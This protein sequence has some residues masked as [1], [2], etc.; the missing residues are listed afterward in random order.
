[1]FVRELQNRAILRIDR[2]V[3]TLYFFNQTV[4]VINSSVDV[5]LLFSLCVFPPGMFAK[6]TFFILLGVMIS[7]ISS[8]VS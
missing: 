8:F 7:L 5:I 2:N 6:T 3:V 1:M 4:D